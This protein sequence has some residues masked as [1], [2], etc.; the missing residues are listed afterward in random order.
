MSDTVPSEYPFNDDRWVRKGVDALVPG[1]VV[2]VEDHPAVRDP[3][4]KTARGSY[5]PLKGPDG[6]PMFSVRRTVAVVVGL[7]PTLG[8]PNGLVAESAAHG[9]YREIYVEAI[10]SEGRD[11]L[12]PGSILSFLQHN[13]A[14]K[15]RQVWRWDLSGPNWPA[16]S[17]MRDRREHLDA[18]VE[19]ARSQRANILE[20][21]DLRE[22]LELVAAVDQ[23]KPKALIEELAPDDVLLDARETAIWASKLWNG[24]AALTPDLRDRLVRIV[25]GLGGEVDPPGLDEALAAAA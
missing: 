2:L 1:D 23:R 11:A 5:V 20:W 10:A 24:Q 19:T 8:F 15:T 9:F 22:A 7:S 17:T 25:V 6:K 14:C 18:F 21:S 3:T 4:R 13:V 16:P 12:A